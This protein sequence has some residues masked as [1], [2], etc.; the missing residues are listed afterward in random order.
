MAERRAHA[1]DARDATKHRTVGIFG[2]NGGIAWQCTY[3]Y[4]SHT[5]PVGIGV[6]FHCHPPAGLCFQI[7]GNDTTL[8][9]G[10]KATL[11]NDPVLLS[12][13]AARGVDATIAIKVEV[14]YAFFHCAKAYLRSKLWQPESWPVTTSSCCILAIVS[15]TP[16]TSTPFPLAF[17]I[18]V[19]LAWRVLYV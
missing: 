5:A 10:G 4:S 19:F 12:M 18:F 9:V 8:R 15:P 16:P 11:S 17:S 3:T 6:V 13:L 14:T 1:R 2:L 7:P